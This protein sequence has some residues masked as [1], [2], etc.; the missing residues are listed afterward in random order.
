MSKGLLDPTAMVN[1]ERHQLIL[2]RFA[3]MTQ[4]GATTIQSMRVESSEDFI[5]NGLLLRLEADVLTDVIA[6]DEYAADYSYEV[7]AS[8][9][10]HFKS[11]YMPTWVTKWKPV[12]YEHKH[13]NVT[14]KLDRLATYP[15]ANVAIQRDK[16][17]FEVM[18]GGVEYIRDEVHQL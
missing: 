18:L 9:W 13:G 15:K 8:P 3:A 16:R 17:F 5:T 1:Y 4:L 7:Y 6:K 11:L 2:K 12:K 14:V 10:Q